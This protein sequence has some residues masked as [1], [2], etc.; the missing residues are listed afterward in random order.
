MLMSGPAERAA[1]LVRSGLR[2]DIVNLRMRCDGLVMQLGRICEVIACPP[3]RSLAPAIMAKT[4]G[5][6]CAFSWFI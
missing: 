2:F 6:P 1:S 4:R 3:F 5:L